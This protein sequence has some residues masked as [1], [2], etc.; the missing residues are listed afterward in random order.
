MFITFFFCKS[1]NQ[2]KNEKIF[3]TSNDK[4]MLPFNKEDIIVKP[5]T[6][7]YYN[8]SNIRYHFH[9]LFENRKIFKINYNFII[10]T[11]INKKISFDENAN[12][13]K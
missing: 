9:D 4:P 13:I 1:Q 3:Y 7:I 6:K 10:Y 8:S 12:N 11:K 5:F 2:I